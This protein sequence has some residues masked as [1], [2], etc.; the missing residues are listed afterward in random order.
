M[1]SDG[2]RQQLWKGHLT[3]T[4][5]LQPTG[6]ESIKALSYL[7]PEP[8]DK[9]I[10]VNI[11]YWDITPDKFIPSLKATHHVSIPTVICICITTS[12]YSPHMFSR[13]SLVETFA[14]GVFAVQLSAVEHLHAVPACCA[15]AW[16]SFERWREHTGSRVYSLSLPLITG[17]PRGLSLPQ[18]P[19]VQDFWI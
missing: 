16:L 6:W 14:S 8:W 9:K 19:R 17:V 10:N 13:N 15:S 2:L 3:P 18:L 1:F 12:L 7:C 11:N 4:K 5:R